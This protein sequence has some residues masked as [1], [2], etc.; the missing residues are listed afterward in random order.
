MRYSLNFKAPSATPHSLFGEFFE[1]EKKVAEKKDT[2]NAKNNTNTKNEFKENGVDESAN[3]EAE[4]PNVIRLI[5]NKNDSYLLVGQPNGPYKTPSN[6][7][8]GIN[9]CN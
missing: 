4:K 3:K 1:E 9:K 2:E 8:N 7:I 5:P 6:C